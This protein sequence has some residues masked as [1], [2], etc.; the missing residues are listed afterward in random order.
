[1]SLSS[2]PPALAQLNKLKEILE[3]VFSSEGTSF[4][5]KL[6]FGK[7]AEAVV[8]AIWDPTVQDFPIMHII[9]I[10]T[11][12]EQPREILEK[13]M[14][15]F[16]RYIDPFPP[17]VLIIPVCFIKEIVNEDNATEE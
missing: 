7:E 9:Y 8:D 12:Q 3:E 17:N 14:E 10:V 5:L 1:M 4:L 11:R 2:V 16:K 6:Y 15:E 13:R